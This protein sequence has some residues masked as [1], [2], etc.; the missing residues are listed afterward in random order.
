MREGLTENGQFIAS[1]SQNQSRPLHSLTNKMFISF[2]TNSWGQLAGFSARFSRQKSAC[3]GREVFEDNSLSINSPRLDPTAV[4]RRGYVSCRWEILAEHRH[5]II[6]N[7][8]ELHLNNPGVCSSS[9]LEL[10]DGVH[11]TDHMRRYCGDQ[12][13]RWLTTSNKLFIEFLFDI[14]DTK[15]KHDFFISLSGSFL[16]NT[17]FSR[18]VI[19]RYCKSKF[20]RYF[21]SHNGVK[22]SPNK[23]MMNQAANAT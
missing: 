3:G 23:L 19:M 12:T 9:F 11:D 5:F 6:V 4:Y 14:E 1:I 13:G 10:S 8:E 18:N 7:F 22:I 20:V 2:R 17:H 16:N 15:V 21:W